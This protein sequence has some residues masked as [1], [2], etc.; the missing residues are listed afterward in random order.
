[1]KFCKTSP[2]QRACVRQCYWERINLTRTQRETL[3][4]QERNKLYAERTK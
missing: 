4:K 2:K 3:T 1:M